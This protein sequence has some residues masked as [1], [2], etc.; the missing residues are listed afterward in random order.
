MSLTELPLSELEVH[1]DV[2]VRAVKP[3]IVREYATDIKSGAVFPPITVFVE[4]GSSRYIVADGHHT[5]E[6]ALMAGH[7]SFQCVTKDGGVHEALQ[8]ALGCNVEHGYRRTKEQT[9]SVVTK[10]LLD[11]EFSKWSNRRVADLCRVDEK[12]VRNV[13]DDLIINGN[14][15]QPETTVGKD[16]KERKSTADNSAVDGAKPKSKARRREPEEIERDRLLDAVNTIRTMP[17]DGA[18][19]AEVMNLE[20]HKGELVFARD[21]LNDILKAME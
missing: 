7:E 9:H 5:R 17:Y 18:T 13:K 15:Q 3:T 12:T 8:H 20:G 21:Q 14:Y 11:P 4:D 1:K 10:A 16:G 2:Q 6:A 19:A